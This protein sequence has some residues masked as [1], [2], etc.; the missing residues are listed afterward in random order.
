MLDPGGR[1]NGTL[2]RSS[3]F[4]HL[5]MYP[6]HPAAEADEG[7]RGVVMESLGKV[8]LMTIEDE[9][10]RSRHG[11]RA[12]IGPL[13]ISSGEEY[14]AQHVEA[15]FT[16]GM[17]APDHFHSGPE[18]WYTLA[19]E[20]CLETSDGRVQIGR[21][22]GRAVMVARGLSMH[23]SATCTEQRRALVL[24]LHETSQDATLPVHD[25]IPKRL[26][27]QNPVDPPQ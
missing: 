3:V 10:W 12:E 16:P 20:T 7:R 8:W 15:V 22:R 23:L 9:H 21:V 2:S 18:A 27:T 6:T 25:W 1:S 5:D 24:I 19:G 4:W 11:A 26:C 14:S 17:T 13:S